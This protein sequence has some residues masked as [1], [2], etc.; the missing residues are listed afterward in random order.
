MRKILFMC[1]L[2]FSNIIIAEIKFSDA[3]IKKNMGK[4]I[5]A[6]FVSISSKE[7]LKINKIKSR[8]SDRIEIHSMIMENEIMKMRK[9][10]TPIIKKNQEFILKKGGNH[11]MIYNLQEDLGN[12][13]E[14][15]LSFEFENNSGEII[16]K[17]VLFRIQ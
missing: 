10:E 3:V 14:A 15:K 1:I 7:N 12:I 9:I 11:L 8:I 4:K 6:G 5:T 16:I 13:S 17:D 2:L